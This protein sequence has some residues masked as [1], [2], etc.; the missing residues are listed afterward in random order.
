MKVRVTLLNENHLGLILGRMPSEQFQATL[1][2]VRK[3][4]ERR[5]KK[6]WGVWQVPVT[7]PNLDYLAKHFPDAD[8]D[9]EAKVVLRYEELTEKRAVRQE[10]KRWLYLY[11]EHKPVIR[12]DESLTTPYKHQTVALDALH[13]T[14]F[15]GLLMEQGTGKTK[16]VVD[17][18]F[19]QAK[20]RMGD[21]PFRVLVI[22]PKRCMKE[23]WEK[24]FAKHAN[25]DI[26]YW[27]GLIYTNAKGVSQITEGVK[28]RVPLKVYVTAYDRMPAM[29]EVYAKLNLDL[30]VCDEST[31]IKSPAAQR[32]RA[33]H[34]LRDHVQRRAILTGSP[35]VN[36]VMDLW[37]QF[38]FLQPGSL[39]YSTYASFRSR[40]AH[41]R[42][43]NSGHKKVTGARRGEELKL[44]MAKHSFV[45]NKDQCLDLPPK[46]YQ[47][48][49]VEMTARQ[50]QLYEQ[51]VEDMV[52]S[53]G[54]GECTA[55][56]IL[57]QLL[58][59]AQICSGFLPNVGDFSDTKLEA[60]EEK[61]EEAN[62]PVLVWARFR[63]DVEKVASKFNCPTLY[64]GTRDPDKSVADFNSGRARMMVGHAL[65]GG[66]GL[67]LLGPPDDK[68][69]TVVYYSNDFALE[70]RIQSEDRCHRIGQTH[71]VTYYDLVC[72][73]SVDYRIAERLQEK[74][75]LAEYVKD[76]DSIKE[77]LLG[78]RHV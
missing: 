28:A 62:S 34:A 3:F 68:C 35:V 31:R 38:E 76:M 77:L 52:A 73:N 30:V 75:D 8:V 47:M 19:W 78:D 13:D 57:T 46:S 5:W 33:C 39:G 61:Y 18:C 24:E 71:P 43:L 59:L 41:F 32:T 14:E 9:P 40:F 45:V 66:L 64:G 42:K 4:P 16:V 20:L 1:A 2:L 15:F 23:V 63:H 54:Q 11:G 22:C 17:E 44:T 7:Q 70:P 60:L 25:P 58:R 6:D 48:V 49:E 29:W 53:L 51:M 27:L 74:R 50:R 21:P 36:N 72:E 37:S 67:T 65:T 56:S 12:Y 10:S 55:K 26:P 69:H